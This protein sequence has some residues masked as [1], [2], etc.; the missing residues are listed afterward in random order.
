MRKPNPFKRGKN[1]VRLII[2]TRTVTTITIKEYAHKFFMH[3]LVENIPQ[4]HDIEVWEVSN[5]NLWR[6]VRRNIRKKILLQDRNLSLDQVTKEDNRSNKQYLYKPRDSCTEVWDNIHLKETLGTDQH[7][8]SFRLT[9]NY[10][11]TLCLYVNATYV[12]SA[13]GAY[14]RNLK[15][16][17]WFI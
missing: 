8:M 15:K 13:K 2:W 12:M 5:P 6:I 4:I 9:Q 11:K 7:F 17:W 3:W 1:W 14:S 16:C 10:H